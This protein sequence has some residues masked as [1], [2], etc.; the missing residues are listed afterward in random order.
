MNVKTADAVPS[1]ARVLNVLGREQKNE[2]MA[3]MTPKTIVHWLWLVTVF[4]YLEP[5]RTWKPYEN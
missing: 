4:R 1:L 3:T 2:M 5:T